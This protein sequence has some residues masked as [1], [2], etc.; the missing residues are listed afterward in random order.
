MAERSIALFDNPK[1]KM[2]FE[3]AQTLLQPVG[4]QGFDLKLSPRTK[5]AE[6]QI[7]DRPVVAAGSLVPTARILSGGETVSGLF[8]DGEVLTP[9]QGQSLVDLEIKANLELGMQSETRETDLAISARGSATGELCFRH[10]IFAEQGKSRLDAFVALL[11]GSR[12]PQLAS[13]AKANPGSVQRFHALLNL[14]LGVEGSYGRSFRSAFSKELFQGLPATLE[15]S[16]EL[17]AK[18]SLGLGLYEQ[19]SLTMARVDSL[20]LNPGWVRLRLQRQDQKKL[21]FGAVVAL[22]AHYDLGSSLVTIVQ[23]AF[24]EIPPLPRA[25]Q[26]FEEIN[27]LAAAGNWQAIESQLSVASA[28]TLSE[29]VDDTGWRQWAAA[30]SEVRDLLDLSGRIVRA[31]QDLGP[32]LQ[33]FWDHLMVSVDLGQGSA[34]RQKLQEVAD[35]DVDHLPLDDLL[36]GEDRKL[37]EMIEALS[38]K[39]LEEIL[40]PPDGE[41]RKLLGQAVSAAKRALKFL[42]ELQALP[43][44]GMAKIEAFS[45]KTGIAGT[46]HF[47]AQNATSLQSLEAFVSERVRGLAGRLVDKAFDRLTKTDQAKV[48]K[49]AQN[50]QKVFEAPGELER[51]LVA[52]LETLKGDIGF[53][54]SLELDRVSQKEALIDLEVNPASRYSQLQSRV[55]KALARG[56]IRSLLQDL[57]DEMKSGDYD[58]KPLPFMLRESVFQSSLVRTSAT[59]TFLSL[60]GLGKAFQQL[61]K[62]INRR[63]E[64]TTLEIKQVPGPAGGTPS[65][66]RHGRFSG[67]Y[68]RTEI[69]NDVTDESAIFLVAKDSGTGLDPEAPFDG[70]EGSTRLHL[71]YSREDGATETKDLVGL[72]SLL[73]ELGFGAMAGAGATMPPEARSRFSFSLALP[74]AALTG[75]VQGLRPKTW[76]GPFLR[77]GRRWFDDP[78]VRIPVPALGQ[79]RG[80]VLEAVTRSELFLDHWTAGSRDFASALTGG[81]MRVRVGGLEKQIQIV[82]GDNDLFTSTFLP[83]KRLIDRR[84]NGL[85][86]QKRINAALETSRQERT[87]AGYRDLLR[88]FAL[89]WQRTS[90]ASGS[91]P[92]SMFPIWLVLSRLSQVDPSVLAEAEGLAMLRWKTAEDP[93]WSEP[94]AWRLEKGLQPFLTAIS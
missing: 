18:A 68:S 43:Q 58:E 76:N 34:V 27:R 35:L 51:K 28:D 4:Q 14:Q 80:Q 70:N 67:G 30:S 31:Y 88:T 3:T 64:K 90:A 53:S 86:H 45:Q 71:T 74:E 10:L 56:S 48:Q 52:D 50:I 57:D 7:F 38:G 44:D 60:T 79:N 89:G 12:L 59:S 19:M 63:I 11:Q 75:F 17:T 66:Q 5:G 8:A 92:S 46:I 93:S 22:Q 84:R 2:A 33:G 29:W 55:E 36:S 9:G 65:F 16:G 82:Q 41:A 81:R 42:N 37:L 85:K 78:L 24:G 20:S 15:V 6:L 62:S 94:L 26:A 54:L 40:L 77:A 47:L 1:I 72:E 39:S 83:I 49:A 91:W 23:K 61:Q 21:S 25:V 69:R 13:I 87:L 73:G 32:R